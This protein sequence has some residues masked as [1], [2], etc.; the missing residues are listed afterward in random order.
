MPAM[1][2][3]AREYQCGGNV[4]TSIKQELPP[5]RVRCGQCLES[6]TCNYEISKRTSLHVCER[7]SIYQW[8][9]IFLYIIKV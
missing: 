7:Y 9:A 4:L 1:I 3:S 2:S 5:I 8:L 6:I